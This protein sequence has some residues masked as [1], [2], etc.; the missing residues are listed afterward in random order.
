M[1]ENEIFKKMVKS[2]F[3]QILSLAGKLKRFFKFCLVHKGTGS[4]GIV[5]QSQEREGTKAADSLDMVRRF[6]RRNKS[7]LSREPKDLI[8]G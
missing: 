2:K 1:V 3:K 6:L 4:K 7:L 5:L 8:I